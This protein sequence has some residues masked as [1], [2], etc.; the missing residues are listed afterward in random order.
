MS[1][2]SKRIG[3]KSNKPP[4]RPSNYVRFENEKKELIAN[5]HDP[6]DPNLT[7]IICDKLKI[8]PK[9]LFKKASSA[10]N[11]KASECNSNDRLINNSVCGVP[12]T[13]NSAHANELPRDDL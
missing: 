7:K 2:N 1:T 5:G 4:G 11:V 8:N 13:F 6:N 3:S 10:Q 12:A 9:T